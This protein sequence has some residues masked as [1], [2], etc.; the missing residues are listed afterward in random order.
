[1]KNTMG[2]V[3]KKCSPCIDAS[4]GVDGF[5]EGEMRRMLLMTE[6]VE[7]QHVEMFESVHCFIRNITRIGD[8]C[9]IPESISEDGKNSMM[10]AN[11]F[12]GAAVRRKFSFGNLVHR[13]L[14]NATAFLQ[15]WFEC[16]PECSANFCERFLRTVHVDDPLADE[17]ELPYIVETADMI[18]VR[19]RKYNR[20]DTRNAV[21][22]HLLTKVRGGVDDE[23]A[24]AHRNE[25]GRAKAMITGIC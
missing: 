19:M 22:Q 9:T 16:I 21:H 14:W 6:S 13:Y 1:M 11:C 25:H 3:R 20:I 8:V 12:D 5:S 7:D 24:F 10:Y 18:E 2:D 23:C 17:I 15:W 4:R